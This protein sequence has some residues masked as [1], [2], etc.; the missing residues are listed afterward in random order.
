MPTEQEFLEFVRNLPEM[1]VLQ[2][3]AQRSG[4]RFGIRGGIVRSLLFGFDA[5]PLSPSLYDFFVSFSDIDVV[6]LSATDW[7]RLE[8]SIVASLP[9][10]GFHRWEVATHVELWDTVK[11]L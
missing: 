8:Q 4:V 9:F 1:Q 5:H 7:P 6:V 3:C 10:A 2:T 11:F